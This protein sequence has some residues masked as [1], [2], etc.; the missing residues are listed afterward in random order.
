[1]LTSANNYANRRTNSVDS[2]G[3][4][5]SRVHYCTCAGTVPV[6]LTSART[7]AIGT[8]VLFYGQV[9]GTVNKVG[10]FCG[11]PPIAL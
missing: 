10:E 11:G 2:N 6:L 3:D 5:A 8:N 1:M 4:A 7:E 9:T